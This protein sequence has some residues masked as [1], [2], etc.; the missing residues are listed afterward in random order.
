MALSIAEK[1][2]GF[3]L[4]PIETF[5]AVRDETFGDAITY[6]VVLLIINAVLSAIVG[7]LGFSA[8]EMP[9]SAIAGAG[10]IGAMIAAFIIAVI[11]G[12]VG[13]I[14][15]SIILHIGVVVMGGH[16]G[17]MQTLKAAVYGLTPYYLLGWIPIIGFLAAIWGLVIE[18]FG[19]R[20]LHDMTTGRAVIAW[21]IS[22][23]IVIVIAVILA[24]VVGLAFLALFGIASSSGPVPV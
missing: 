23:V 20:E 8:M 17:F 13:L 7:F 24:V 11:A 2:Q 21:L 16:G 1:I 15:G 6:F 12:I 22:L 4:R 9:G 14:V 3:I 19:I 10:G 18:I 5:R